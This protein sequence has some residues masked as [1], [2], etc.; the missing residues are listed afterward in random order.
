MCVTLNTA[1]LVKKN[2]FK[3]TEKKRNGTTT[4]ILVGLCQRRV[5]DD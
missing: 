2:I 3:N 1:L 4:N 5:C